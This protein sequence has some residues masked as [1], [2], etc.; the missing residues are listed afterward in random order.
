VKRSLF[1]IVVGAWI[2]LS[3]WLLGF[4]N[5]SVMRWSNVLFGLALLLVGVW[6]ISEEV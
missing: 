4:S 5:I 3:P 1:E 2:L 6:T